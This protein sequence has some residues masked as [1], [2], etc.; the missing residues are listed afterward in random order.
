MPN[1][2]TASPSLTMQRLHAAWRR[3][4]REDG[5]D[6]PGPDGDGADDPDLSTTPRRERATKLVLSLVIPSYHRDM[7][8]AGITIAKKGL[9]K[10][11]RVLMIMGL[12]CVVG[13]SCGD[14]RFC[15]RK[16]V[17]EQRILEELGEPDA[18]AARLGDEIAIFPFAGPRDARLEWPSDTRYTFYYLSDGI[19]VVIVEGRVR[20]SSV[21]NGH[22]REMVVHALDE[23][24]R[25]GE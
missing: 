8:T 12:V 7:D 9:V 25:S 21:L 14:G 24:Q 22:T 3:E 13:C 10:L 16:G 19:K 18:V 15:L 17:S 5:Q 2:P 6:N 23:L 4:D 1:D 20:E 11:C